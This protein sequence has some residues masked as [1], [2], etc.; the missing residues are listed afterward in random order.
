MTDTTPRVASEEGAA[1]EL[2]AQRNWTGSV[3][4]ERAASPQ[5]ESGP[6]GDT[7]DHRPVI[8]MPEASGNNGAVGNRNSTP[9]GLG[10]EGVSSVSVSPPEP[11]TAEAGTTPYQQGSRGSESVDVMTARNE[12]DELAGTTGKLEKLLDRFTEATRDYVLLL[13]TP[14]ILSGQV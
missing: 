2:N 1:R 13:A 10:T 6:T 12:A 14:K 8:A 4:P 11:R 5:S 9:M 7:E 3:Y